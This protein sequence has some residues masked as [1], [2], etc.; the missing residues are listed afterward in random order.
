MPTAYKMLA[1]ALMYTWIQTRLK[2]PRVF[3]VSG[4]NSKYDDSIDEKD[5]KGH[6]NNKKCVLLIERLLN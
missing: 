4:K 3:F 5:T 2:K 6:A 1:S